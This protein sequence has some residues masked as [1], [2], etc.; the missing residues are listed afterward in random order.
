MRF[1]VEHTFKG[2][3]IDDYHKILQDSAGCKLYSLDEATDETT[4]T[5]QILNESAI[6]PDEAFSAGEF[7]EELAREVRRLPEREQ[8]VLS[9]Y[10]ERELN[11]KEIGQV[12]G[13]SESRV[14]Q[15]HVQALARMRA[16]VN[17]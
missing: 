16:R 6:T 2:I 10:Y 5:R 14:C 7:R 17:R 15:I 11:L 8:L 12:L 1:R 4:Q 3:S 13:V 9:L